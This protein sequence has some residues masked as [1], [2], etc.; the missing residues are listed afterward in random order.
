M[1]LPWKRKPKRFATGGVIRIQALD[2]EAASKAVVD[3]LR[4]Y[5]RTRQRTPVERIKCRT[6][7]HAKYGG[8]PPEAA[9]NALMAAVWDRDPRPLQRFGV[10]LFP[11]QL[12]FDA[13]PVYM[14]QTRQVVEKPS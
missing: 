8:R 7:E 13:L 11:W 1:K 3:V 9:W 4:S 14:A 2:P 10:M 5:E 6:D 12:G